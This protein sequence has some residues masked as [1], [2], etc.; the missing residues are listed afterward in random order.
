MAKHLP[1]ESQ[2]YW[3]RLDDQSVNQ[4]FLRNQPVE[5]DVTEFMVVRWDVTQQ[6]WVPAFAPLLSLAAGFQGNLINQNTLGIA[7]QLDAINRV[8]DVVLK[9]GVCDGFTG[10]TAGA[11]YWLSATAGGI[12]TTRPGVG[13]ALK[14]GR[15]LSTTKLFLDISYFRFSNHLLTPIDWAQK[16]AH[17]ADWTLIAGSGTVSYDSS[18]DGRFGTGVFKFTGNTTW[19]LNA[20][21]PASV[22]MGLGGVAHYATASGAG[23]ISF[24][25]EQY[26]ASLSFLANLN[27]IASSVAT[28]TTWAYAQA[29]ETGT[30]MNASTRWVRPLLTIPSNAGTTYVDGWLIWN[31]TFARIAN[32]SNTA[33]FATTANYA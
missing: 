9:G 19:V 10:L 31:P 24:G 28:S 5:D 30:N 16:D 25:V 23:T 15:A 17:V 32:F 2:Q 18:I 14:I 20:Y 3:T 22:F 7:I 26:S 4:F 12:T 11:D 27:F 33:Q 1:N 21:Y 8:C 29:L 6:K 13:P